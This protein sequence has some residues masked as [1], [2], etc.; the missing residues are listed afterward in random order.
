MLRRPLHELS[1]SDLIDLLIEIEALKDRAEALLMERKKDG[2][3][4]K[5]SAAEQLVSLVRN[6]E[7]QKHLAR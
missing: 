6:N 7:G 2:R 3:S 5:K 1:D 4:D